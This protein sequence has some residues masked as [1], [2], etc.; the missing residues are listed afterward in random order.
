MTTNPTT[1]IVSERVDDI[2]VLFSYLME[3]EATDLLDAHFPTHDNW[4]GLSLGWTARR[5]E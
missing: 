2:P 5:L 3:M 4:N 1:N